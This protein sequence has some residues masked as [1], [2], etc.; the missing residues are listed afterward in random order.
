MFRPLLQVLPAA[1]LLFVQ[2]A[3]AAVSSEA[4]IFRTEKADIRVTKVAGDLDHPWG[5]LFLPDGSILLNERGSAMVLIAPDGKSKSAVAGVPDFFAWGQAGLMDLVPAPD[6]ETSGTIYFTYTEGVEGSLGTA[7]ARAKLVRMGKGARLEDVK[8]LVR[9]E[10]RTESLDNFGSRILPA[11]DG[12]LF[13]AFGDRMQGE[14]AQDPFDTAGKVMRV[15]PDGSIPPD[16]PFADG[17]KALKE[18]W[19]TGHRNIQGMAIQ[20]GTGALWTVEHGPQGGDEINRPQAGGNY[21]WPVITY[22]RDYSGDPVGIGTH[23]EGMEQPIHYWV[24]SIAPSGMIFHDG[25]AIPAW[26]DDLLVGALRDQMIVRLEIADGKVVHEERMIQ[27]EF[28]RIRTLRNG[29]DGAIWFSTDE[30]EG[31]LYRIAPAD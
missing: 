26:K 10:K 14:R 18:I 31:A 11:P 3:G 2:G 22:G 28:G 8:V 20:P 21:G 1:T 23:A 9:M 15:N 29:P 17:G 30:D 12:T 4:R 19:S 27:G 13:V 25:S 16:N 7:A 6:F 24:P 5:F